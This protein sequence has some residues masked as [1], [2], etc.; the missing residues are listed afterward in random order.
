MDPQQQNQLEE[1]IRRA[2]E[3]GVSD[4][5]IRGEL[6]KAGW[7]D[8]DIPLGTR[9]NSGT[10]RV[11]LWPIVFIGSLCYV[12]TV[13][14][15]LFISCRLFTCEGMAIFWHA[16]VAVA[17]GGIALS[18]VFFGYLWLAVPNRSLIRALAFTA[19]CV[20]ANNILL[21]TPLVIYVTAIAYAYRDLD[22]RA[23]RRQGL[24]LFIAI[25]IAGASF[26][27][28]ALVPFFSNGKFYWINTVEYFGIFLVLVAV[29]WV[30]IRR[31]APSLVRWALSAGIALSYIIFSITTTMF[32]VQSA[33]DLVVVGDGGQRT[34]AVSVATAPLVVDEPYMP[35]GIHAVGIKVRFNLLLKNAAFGSEVRPDLFRTVPS[36][37]DRAAEQNIVDIL[38]SSAGLNIT[39]WRD[40]SEPDDSCIS[41]TFYQE[42]NKTYTMEAIYMPRFVGDGCHEE[43]SGELPRM[44]WEIQFMRFV[45]KDE[46]SARK[47]YLSLAIIDPNPVRVGLQHDYDV[48]EFYRNAIELYPNVC[49]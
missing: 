23:P 12:V 14:T 15:T 47:R 21:I 27:D 46:E 16:P 2:R 26:I 30:L 41:N 29:A 39:C 45:Y 36:Y 42:P 22:P 34:E 13:L 49:R 18:I 38:G 17:L 35:D 25:L 8:A 1:Y 48:N 44:Q 43:I 32:R 24:P 20:V 9:P 33:G 19:I 31:E 10:V 3:A 6:L 7:A 4:E 37:L 40:I 28:R 11:R 5:T